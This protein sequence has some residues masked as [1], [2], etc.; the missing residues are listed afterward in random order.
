MLMMR[1]CKTPCVSG[2][3]EGADTFTR[4]KHSSS[5]VEEDCYKDGNYTEK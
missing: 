2:C 1:H 5:K 3:R 4:W